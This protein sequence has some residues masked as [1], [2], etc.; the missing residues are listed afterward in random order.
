LY[1]EFLRPPD[2]DAPKATS[3]F[4]RLSI[5]AGQNSRLTSFR[6]QHPLALAGAW[7]AADGDVAIAITSIADQPQTL[8]FTLDAD[9]YHLPQPR[10]VYRIDDT[11]RH[12]LESPTGEDTEVA[13]ELPPREAWII[14]FSGN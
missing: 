2:L 3:D 11:G 12:P 4:S 1:G 7:R 14:E 8:R 10:R 6:K 9:Y 5:Y 13:I